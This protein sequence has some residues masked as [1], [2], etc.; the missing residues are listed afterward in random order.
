MNCSD[1]TEV[2]FAWKRMESDIAFVFTFAW[3][4]HNLHIYCSVLHG[5]RRHHANHERE[6]LRSLI[7]S[8]QRLGEHVSVVRN[9]R[10][11]GEEQKAVRSDSPN[12]FHL[13]RRAPGSV[14]S[15]TCAVFF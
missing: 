5:G 12:L 9:V 11:V 7:S 2:I 1:Q 15:R 4:E 3:C 6:E 10:S 8:R 14:S 13:R